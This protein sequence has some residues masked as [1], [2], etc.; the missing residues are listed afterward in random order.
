MS[1]KALRSVALTL[2]VTV[3]PVLAQLR[4]VLMSRE[5]V[6]QSEEIRVRDAFGKL[7]LVEGV[8][9]SGEIDVPVWRDDIEAD[10]RAWIKA[11]GR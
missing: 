10:F 4:F 8:Y 1:T 7:R 3:L 6:E 2:I 9:T 5:V 11:G